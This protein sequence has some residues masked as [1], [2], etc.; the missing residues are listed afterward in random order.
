[1]PKDDYFKPLADAL[2]PYSY[3][4]KYSD[5]Q[6]VVMQSGNGAEVTF[7][8]VGSNPTKVTIM[9]GEGDEWAIRQVADLLQTHPGFEFQ[10]EAS[11]EAPWTIQFKESKLAQLGVVRD[12]LLG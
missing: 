12:T 7:E 2:L 3:T 4:V 11:G 9:A 8:K 6:K 1:M 5:G 10:K